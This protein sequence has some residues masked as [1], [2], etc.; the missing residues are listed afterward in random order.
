M[1]KCVFLKQKDKQYI[2]YWRKIKELGLSK[3]VSNK[4]NPADAKSRAPD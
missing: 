1:I 4:A 2:H 3:S